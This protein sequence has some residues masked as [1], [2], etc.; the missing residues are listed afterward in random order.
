[1]S[2]ISKVSLLRELVK[3]FVIQRNWVPTYFYS[4]GNAGVENIL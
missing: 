4:F 2:N 1:M 3:S